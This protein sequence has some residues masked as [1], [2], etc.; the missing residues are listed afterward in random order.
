VKEI[1]PQSKGA[2]RSL[3]WSILFYVLTLEWVIPQWKDYQ[4]WRQGGYCK[5]HLSPRGRG[6]EQE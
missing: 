4:D 5:I 6:F 1:P 2:G 3:E